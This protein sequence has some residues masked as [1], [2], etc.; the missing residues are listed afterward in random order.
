MVNPMMTLAEQWFIMVNPIT[1]LLAFGA[2]LFWGWLVSSVLDKDQAFYH[3]S[4]GKWNIAHMTAGLLG[5]GVMLSP[6][7]EPWWFAVSFPAGMLVMLSTTLV[8]WNF[9]NKNVPEEAIYHL[10]T[11]GLTDRMAKRAAAKAAADANISFVDSDGT[12]RIPPDRESDSFA[13]HIAAEEFLTPALLASAVKVE[14]TPG[15]NGQYSI[16]QYV[17]TIRYRRDPID[18]KEANAIIGYLKT[19][20]GLDVSDARRKQVGDMG[21]KFG[22]ST[23]ELRIRTA[24]SSQGQQLVVDFDLRKAVRV[25]PNKLGFLKR[26]FE[27]LDSV[28]SDQRGTVL[29]TAPKS[30]GRTT[31][32]YGLLDRHDAF[33]NNIRTLELEHLIQL[34]GVGHTEFEQTEDGPDFATQLRSMLRRDPNIMMVAELIDAN[35]AKEAASPGA[36]GPLMYVGVRSNSGLEGLAT[37][38]QAVGDLPMA[39]A[40]LRAVV[41]QLLVRRLC[42]NCKIAYSPAAEQLKKIGLNADQVKQL[43]K[44]SGKIIE[45]NKEEQCP[46]CAGLG[47]RGVVGVYEIMAFDKDARGLIAKG[48][49]NGLRAHL[50][51]QKMITMQQ[52]AL[53]K[54]ID[55]VTGIEEVIRV[56]RSQQQQKSNKKQTSSS[57]SKK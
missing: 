18:G 29:V 40:P 17:D 51:R 47:Y 28:I 42:D 55:G 31:T 33:V 43:Y 32:L 48:D 39:A 34:D 2:L 44:P 3:F 35:T 5:F 13:I 27:Q 22:A 7:P 6:Y 38:C 24:G 11:K 45:R 19:H 56:T 23:H 16:A 8:Y 26:Q 41:S 49:L 37:W 12:T 15:P 1:P 54:A 46:S 57:S 14:L 53:R 20:A 52:A 4:T 9:R 50:G 21:A 36:D 10:N 30:T 25:L